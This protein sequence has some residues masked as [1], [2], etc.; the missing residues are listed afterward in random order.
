VQVEIFDRYAALSERAAAMVADLMRRRT[1]AV[2]GLPTGSTPLGFYREL[3]RSRISFAQAQTFNLDE[4]VGLPGAHPESYCHF[5]QEHLFRHVDLDPARIHIPDG[6]AP[7][8][9]AECRRYEE[10]LRQAGG[11]DVVLLGLGLNGHIGFN[12]P[13]TPWNLRTHK[14][15][16]DESTRRANAR[17]FDSPDEVPREA[18]TMGIAT[19]LE[20]RQ[21][22]LLASGAAKASIVREV[23]RGEVSEQVPAT[24]LRS[25]LNVTVLL[26]REA[27]ALL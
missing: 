27:A 16:L 7:D 15:V 6:M 10:A 4:Y 13:G 18:L 26:D 23:L 19:I 11:L 3:T 1:D 12:E 24:A 9:E 20:A 21:I 5:M 17:F 25:H 22:L 14:V 8:P 2:L